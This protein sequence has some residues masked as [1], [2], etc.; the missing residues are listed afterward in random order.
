MRTSQD[1]FLHL[2]HPHPVSS[3]FIF[4]A[5]AEILGARLVSYRDWILALEES[6]TDNDDVVEAFQHNNPALL[7]VDF[8]HSLYRPSSTAYTDTEAFGFP[9][10]SIER[11]LAAAPKALRNISPLSRVDIQRWI[12]Y[13]KQM[14]LLR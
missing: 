4:E 8:Y 14:G 10:P 12:L 3:S 11:A 5:F 13:W 9:T 1:T 6:R 7:L 2:T